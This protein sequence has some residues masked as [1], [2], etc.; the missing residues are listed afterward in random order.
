MQRRLA[1]KVILTPVLS[2]AIASNLFAQ[3]KPGGGKKGGS[4]KEGGGAQGKDK[5]NEVKFSGTIKQ[6]TSQGIVVDSDDSK[7]YL[8]GFGSN[9]D[10]NVE[11]E[12]SQD[13]LA[14]GTSLEFDVDLNREGKPVKEIQG[15]TVIELSNLNP[16]G[17]FPTTIP[18]AFSLQN[19]SATKTFMARGR[20]TSYKEGMLTL[21]TGSK[22]I[23]VKVSK[24]FSLEVRLS[25]WRLASVGDT[26]KG[27][28]DLPP[29]A[30]AGL[31]RVVARRLT[32]RTAKP[33]EPKGAKRE[34]EKAKSS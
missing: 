12:A 9:S 7:H 24:N 32:I 6:I 30:N 23:V 1:F 11:G 18:D 15:L 14:P 4:N 13:F 29:Q 19:A 28:G 33:I 8:I 21:Q 3:K 16:P 25:N 31:M 20:V 17:L 2:V 26:V 27:A 5:A 10:V 34:N 22:S